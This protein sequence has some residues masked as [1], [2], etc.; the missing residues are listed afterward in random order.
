[1]A[2]FSEVQRWRNIASFSTS[3]L[4]DYVSL[5]AIELELAKRSLIRDVI[6]YSILGLS[7]MFSLAFICFA[8]ILSAAH[9]TY[10][11]EIGWGVALFW[12]LVAA[13]AYLISRR[14]SDPGMFAA[15]SEELQ[16]DIKAIKESA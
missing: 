7:A 6:L 4:Q 13:S 8:I 12:V 16:G 1:M 3:R 14:R 9:T 11:V 15:L 10:Y 2:L 5:I